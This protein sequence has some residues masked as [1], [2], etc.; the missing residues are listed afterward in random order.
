MF[1]GKAIRGILGALALAI[2]FIASSS[3]YAQEV[4]GPEPVYVG[5][6]EHVDRTVTQA[7]LVG[8]GG[9]V[10][11]NGDL[12]NDQVEYWQ[13]QH[14]D[15]SGWRNVAY[16]P[17]FDGER[18]YSVRFNQPGPYYYR[19]IA[20]M[21]DGQ[22]VKSNA[23]RITVSPDGSGLGPDP[24]MAMPVVTLTGP[25]HQVKR[26]AYVT[27]RAHVEGGQK[28]ANFRWDRLHHDGRFMK[29]LRPSGD[30]VEVQF[31]SPG[32]RTWRVLVVV[33]GY[34]YYPSISVTW[35]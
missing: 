5:V 23:I 29:V 20:K 21:D 16:K 33:D 17:S 34:A 7:E 3:I 9:N 27:M 11:V 15:L 22:R 2:M 13:W 28:N 14:E 35:K 26:C 18:R 31:C 19:F 10:Y 25:T 8:I 32:K 24:D 30:N 4:D 12:V 1:K 6:I